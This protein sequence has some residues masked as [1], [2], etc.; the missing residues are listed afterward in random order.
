MIHHCISIGEKTYRYEK[1]VKFGSVLVRGEFSPIPILLFFLNH[2]RKCQ[3]VRKFVL[4]KLSYMIVFKNTLQGQI[5]I[6]IFNL[7]KGI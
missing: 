5:G 3:G 2:S 1:I 6:T 7:N 4:E